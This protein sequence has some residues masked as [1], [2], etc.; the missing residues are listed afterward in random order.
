M[1]V[2]TSGKIFPGSHLRPF[3]EDA[4]ALPTPRTPG[5]VQLTGKAGDC[6]LFP[7]SLWHGPTSNRSGRARK[8][9]LYN[10]CQMFVRWYDFELTSE[11]K[12]RCTPR[13]RRLL[14]DLGS[15]FR[16][17]SY[18]YAPVDQVEVIQHTGASATEAR[19][20]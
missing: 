15:D 4:D 1:I 20:R 8:T 7:H 18:F 17:G 11:V 12:E 6:Y 3:P 2:R 9:L 10:Y 16:P 19:R 13:Q 14:G 5:A